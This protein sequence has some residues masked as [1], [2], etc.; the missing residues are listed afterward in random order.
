MPLRAEDTL[1][2]AIE[3][4]IE[5]LQLIDRNWR[6]LYVN[7]AAAR[8]GHTTR[9]SLL[10]RTMMECYPGFDETPFF[11]V[12]QQVL[13]T[14][15]PQRV[16][17]EFTYPDKTKCWFELH[18]ESVSQGLLIRS[19]D[20]T[21]RKNLEDQLRHA[22]KMEAIGRL[23]GGIAHDFNNKLAIILVYCEMALDQLPSDSKVATYFNR[24]LEAV[25]QS[26]SLTKQLLAFS[27]RQVL[28]LRLIDL[29]SLLGKFKNSLAQLLGENIR[30]DF[31]LS[32]NLK[33]VQ[34]DPTQ[35]D[36]ILLNLC[37]NARDAM[38]EGGVLT[39]ETKNVVLDDEYAKM[40]AGVTPG[41][42]V[43]LSVSDSGIG[44]T[45][46]TL[47]HIFEPFFTTKQEKGTG[48]GL[49]TVHGIVKQSR[50]HIWVYS[51]P[52]MGTVF[53]IYLPAVHEKA[54]EV[55]PEEKAVVSYS[56]SEEVLL[57]E[58]DPLLREA[59][60]TALRAAGYKVH[61]AADPEQALKI[62][63]QE[64]DRLAIV[65]TDLVLPVMNG[66]DLVEKI[67][68]RKP[69]FKAVF[70]SGY[71]ENSIVHQGILDTESVLMQKPISIRNMLETIRLVLEGK[72]TKGLV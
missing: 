36:Q 72:L 31:H 21:D 5:G 18:I 65:V 68:S 55:R 40:H 32:Q 44:M 47:S 37:I 19:V 28:D 62:F 6:Y 2:L 66:K 43:M 42:Y 10:G 20:I 70:M 59:Y 50:G 25:Q 52:G 26:S 12:L 27:R 23:A 54:E 7:E 17:N 1:K 71:T 49:P 4:T 16:E 30:V 22:Q 39:I 57:V 45:K 58:D 46:E 33:S 14:G 29:N 38:P 3:Q 53:K 64:K 8:H 56:G 63:D 34:A 48:L 13:K 69:D 15:E 60:T 11:E 51:E 9:E 24:I 61:V 41:R 35:I 67:R